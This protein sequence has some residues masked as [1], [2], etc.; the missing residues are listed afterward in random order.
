MLEELENAQIGQGL[1]EGKS[2]QE[3]AALGL[4]GALEPKVF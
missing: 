1:A 4:T 3:L 2:P